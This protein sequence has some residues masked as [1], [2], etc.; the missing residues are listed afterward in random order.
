MNLIEFNNTDVSITYSPLLLSLK[1]F[2]QLIDRDKS[3]DKSMAKKEIAFISFYIDVKSIYMYITD[4]KERFEE[5]VKDL[6][7]PKDWKIDS[8]VAE[9]INFYKEKSTTV[10]SSIYRRACKAAMD[11]ASYLQKADTLLE[12]RDENGKVVTDISKIT[13]ALEKVPKIMSNLN[14]AHQELIR[15]QK[16]VEGRSKGSKQFNMYEDGLN[17]EDE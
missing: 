8:V 11:I 9:A 7:L 17:Y 16:I 5:L 10:N 6:E 1:P 3:K 2:K 13:S 12:E 4:D 14:I 15:E